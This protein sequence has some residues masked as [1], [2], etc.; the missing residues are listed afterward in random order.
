MW[1]HLITGGDSYFKERQLASQAKKESKGSP[2]GVPPVC[3]CLWRICRP[4]GPTAGAKRPD[5]AEGRE[6]ERSETV[7]PEATD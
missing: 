5:A 3:G 7:V 1:R 4:K 2:Q 6:G